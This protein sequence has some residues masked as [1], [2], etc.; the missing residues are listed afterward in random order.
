M[1]RT[2]SGE[3][4]R[5]LTLLT[6]EFGKIDVVAKGARKAGS[7]LAGSSE[8]LVRARFG[9]AEG[10]YQRF[11]TQVEPVT[12]YPGIRGD[13]DRMMAGLACAEVVSASLEYESQVLEI[14]ELMTAALESLAT[15]D[16]PLVVMVWVLSR[17]LVEEGQNP[18]W[19]VCNVTGAPLDVSPG[20]VSAHG[21]GY[22]S[23]EAAT[24][25]EDVTWASGE[26]LI[27]LNKIA[28]LENPPPRI[29]GARECA[30]ILVRFWKGILN[31]GLPAC[32]AAVREAMVNGE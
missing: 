20:A 14:Y 19:T 13:Y 22:I 32:E 11:V 10:K 2:D 28:E 24:Q 16:S 29:K 7:R 8:P 31:R 26:T 21:G 30:E 23:R 4:D 18:D 5:R 3:S 15:H 27:A 12:S 1:R 17:L 25:Y 9:W 6:E